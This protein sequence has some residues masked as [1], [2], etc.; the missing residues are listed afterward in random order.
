LTAVIAAAVV[1]TNDMATIFVVWIPLL[2]L[3]VL[4]I[5]LSWLVYLKKKRKS[6]NAEA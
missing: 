4:S 1:P 3:Y 2:G 5:G 6:K